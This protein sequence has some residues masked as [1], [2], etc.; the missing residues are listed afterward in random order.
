MYKN[1]R[2]TGII[3]VHL[4][5]GDEL[6]TVKEIGEEDEVILVTEH[7][8]AIRFKCLDVR[9]MGRGTAG[10]KGIALRKG[11]RVVAG[12]VVG[13]EGER[14]DVLTVSEHGYGKRTHIENYRLQSR[15]GKGIITMKTTPK[16][17]ALVG[18]IMVEVK[19]EII[20]LTSGNK[21]IRIKANEIRKVG[22]AT[23]GV[24]LVSMDNGDHVVGFDLVRDK[25]EDL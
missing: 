19:D 7:G 9:A 11:D 13:E 12:V 22:R 5:E 25:P 1:C 14:E 2:S 17:G 15:G 4:K 8:F 20:L 21:V 10:V 18:A 24:R 16:T 23:Q 3:A 6:M